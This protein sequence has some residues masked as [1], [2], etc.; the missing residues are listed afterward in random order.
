ML[1]MLQRKIVQYWK[2]AKEK[3]KIKINSVTIA[4]KTAKL[5]NYNQTFPGENREID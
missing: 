4:L 1:I 3:R 2:A 5:I